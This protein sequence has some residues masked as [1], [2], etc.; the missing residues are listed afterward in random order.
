V[1]AL[2]LPALLRLVSRPHLAAHRL[3]TALTVI[4]VA[5][6]VAAVIGIADASRSVLASFE[7]MVRTVAG[8]C[9]LEVTSAAGLLDDDLVERVAAQRG[10]KAAA[11]IIET[12]VPLADEPTRSVYL[13]GI[14]F[15][16][17]PVW[18]A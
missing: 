11:A 9:E 1:P 6:G 4:G 14:D 13:L 12:F 18:S 7:H 10:V 16:R 2:L 5:L 15:L 17:S 3:R 8:D